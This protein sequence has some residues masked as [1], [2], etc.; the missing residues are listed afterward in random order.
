MR[1]SP[2]FLGILLLLVPSMMDARGESDPIGWFEPLPREGKRATW[3]Q[4]QDIVIVGANLKGKY[5]MQDGFPADRELCLTSETNENDVQCFN[6]KDP[7]IKQWSQNM[8]V[9]AIPD[10][11]LPRGSVKIR[12][13]TKKQECKSLTGPDTIGISCGKVLKWVDDVLVGSYELVPQVTAL[14]DL[15]TGG[16]VRGNF[17]PGKEYEVRGHWFGAG[18]GKIRIN[19]RELFVS[20]IKLWLPG[21]VVIRPSLGGKFVE[22]HNG[23]GWSPPAPEFAGGP[24][25]KLLRVRTQVERSGSRRLRHVYDASLLRVSPFLGPRRG[26]E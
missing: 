17:V 10:D 21:A 1:F 4:G 15:E 26:K 7:V 19:G 6:P 8:I 13:Q 24:L 9:A 14:V 25:W 11:V 2:I 16:E 5:S 23:V 22:V 3:T 18:R 12:F 20:D